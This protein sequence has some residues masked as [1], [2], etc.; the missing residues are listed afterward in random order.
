[1]KK[2]RMSELTVEYFRLSSEVY[3]KIAEI[4]GQFP[5]EEFSF[6]KECLPQYDERFIEKLSLKTVQDDKKIILVT[7][8]NGLTI[9][10]L[11]EEMLTDNF[12]LMVDL[13]KEFE[14][15]LTSGAS[16]E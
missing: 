10:P 11:E 12:L 9:S 6:D 7:Y 3:E 16:N 14:K 15:Q 1:M 2:K 4:L 13:A 5:G 8:C